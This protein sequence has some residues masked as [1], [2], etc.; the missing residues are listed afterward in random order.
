MNMICA[1]QNAIHSSYLRELKKKNRIFKTKMKK[2]NIKD[3]HKNSA[4]VNK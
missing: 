1:I 3:K 2:K 4:K